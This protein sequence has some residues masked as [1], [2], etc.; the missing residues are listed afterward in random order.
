MPRGA[1]ACYASRGLSA[2]HGGQMIVSM[3]NLTL[4]EF[5]ELEPPVMIRDV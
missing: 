2:R 1:G 5:L 3:R 4:P